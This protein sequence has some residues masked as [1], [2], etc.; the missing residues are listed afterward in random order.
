MNIQLI[1]K[2]L[3]DH[4]KEEI[5]IHKDIFSE[6]GGDVK[7]LVEKHLSDT[8]TIHKAFWKKLK[9]AAESK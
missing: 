6:A 5:R 9:K 2:A 3:K 4:A 1:L 8:M 7:N